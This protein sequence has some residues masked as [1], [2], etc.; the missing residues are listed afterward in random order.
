M[1]TVAIEYCEPCGHLEQAAD[2]Q[3]AILE[4]CSDELAGVTLIPGDGGIFQVRMDDEVIFDTDESDYDQSTIVEAV[5]EFLP[6]CEHSA[7]DCC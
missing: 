4:S 1:T 3:R 7:V 5:C 2:S 6:E